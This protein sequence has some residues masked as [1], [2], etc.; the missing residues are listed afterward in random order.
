MDLAPWFLFAHVLGAIIAFGPTFSFPIMGRLGALEPEHDNFATRLS[1]AISRIQVVPFAILQGVTGAGI[2]VTR[3]IDVLRV[4]WLM[5]AIGLYVIALGYAILVQTPT[6]RRVIELSSAVPGRAA[7]PELLA[8]V[9]RI[10][11][12]GLFLTLAIVSIVFLMV[13]KP[14]F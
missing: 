11:M 1:G 6:L 12:G 10:Q 4:P 5:L 8:L 13:V 7:P 3:T 9:R 2:I 14:T